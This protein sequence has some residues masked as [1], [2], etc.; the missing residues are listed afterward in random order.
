MIEQIVNRIVEQY[1]P[2]KI[3]LFGSYAY[4][5]PDAGS[6]VDLLIVKET[7]E[8]P[9]DRRVTVRRI[10][11]APRRG[12]PFSP[13]VIT[14]QE[15]DRRIELGDPFYHEIIARGEVLYARS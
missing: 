5:T 6:D 9:I 14:P 7:D 1:R 3:I 4:G 10:A 15:L 12:L 8:R 13:L 11:Y 2:E